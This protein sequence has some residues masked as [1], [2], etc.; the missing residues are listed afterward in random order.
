MSA[1]YR[2]VIKGVKEGFTKEQVASQLAA[3]F[4]VNEDQ[5]RSQ[6]DSSSFVVK[7]GIDLQSTEK[8][9][10]A[11]EQRGCICAIEAEAEPENATD[12]PV[13]PESMSKSP[14]VTPT[15]TEPV[16][17]KQPTEEKSGIIKCLKCG[18]QLPVT[19]KFCRSCGAEQATR[20][21]NARQSIQAKVVE[22]SPQVEKS[23]SAKIAIISASLVA[24]VV[25]ASG[26]YMLWKKQKHAVDTQPVASSSSPQN[27]TE[28]TAQTSNQDSDK[29][30]LLQG[31]WS[32]TSDRDP[33]DVFLT[34]FGAGG[35][36]E[37]ITNL[38]G[39]N[40][41]IGT[42]RLTNQALDININ[43]IPELAALQQSPNVS[44]SEGAEI[45]YLD[46]NNLQM[47][48]WSNTNPHDR[49]TESCK[50]K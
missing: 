45:K 4:K 35:E 6:L 39:V 11:L 14:S 28:A 42:Y 29:G 26:G 12:H 15:S 24:L 18:F 47:L 2:V 3:L 38:G 37:D 20:G 40:H 48:S 10:G 27:Q 30:K 43:K 44:L 1:T 36:Y 33:N 22:T 21:I 23:S 16:P 25:V 8:Y 19:A 13:E 5:I 46:S 7:K 17:L 50:K 34:I 49:T 41:R 31:T 9:Q 32:C